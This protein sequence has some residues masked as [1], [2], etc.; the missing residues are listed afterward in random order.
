[1]GDGKENLGDEIIIGNHHGFKKE[2]N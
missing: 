2:L 1:M